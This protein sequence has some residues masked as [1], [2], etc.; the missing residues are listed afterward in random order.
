MALQRVVGGVGRLL[1]TVGT[2]ILL[3]VAYQLWGTGVREAQAQSELTEAFSEALVAE[4]VPPGEAPLAPPSGEAAAV[5]RIPKLG[6]EKAV[7]EGVGVADLKKGP[8]H[9][10]DTPMPGQAGN[11]AIAGHRTTYGAPFYELDRLEAGDEIVVRTLQ[12][13][14]RYA[15]DRTMVVRPEEVQVLDPTEESRLTLTTCNPRYSARERLI[16]SAVLLDTPVPAPDP[17]ESPSGEAEPVSEAGT[18]GPAALTGDPSARTPALLWGA[19]AAGLWLTTLQI[20]HRWRRLPA[21]VLG[22][23]VVAVVLFLCFEQVAR[24]FPANI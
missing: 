16:V 21:Y 19:L 13:E 7:V 12:G 1:I 6:L 9:Y 24:L 3:F 4:A 8:G 14:F 20:A 18:E 2:V 11:A 22:V 17:V 10:P 5:I 15:V 23:P